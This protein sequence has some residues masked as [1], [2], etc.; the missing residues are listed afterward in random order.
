M[1]AKDTIAGLIIG[2]ATGLALGL[3][4]APRKGSE[5]REAIAKTSGDYF[6]RI[7][8]D[9]KSTVES[10]MDKFMKKNS[11]RA[12]ERARRQI[13]EVKRELEKIKVN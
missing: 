6:D 13:E 7:S 9:V 1:K 11:S 4:F 12:E 8:D 2:A 5:T 10:T 3:L